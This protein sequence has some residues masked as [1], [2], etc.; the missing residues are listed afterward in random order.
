MSNCTWE[1]H[2]FNI[3]LKL[4]TLRLESLNVMLHV[5]TLHNSV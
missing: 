1:F 4:E 3:Y 5:A 2:V